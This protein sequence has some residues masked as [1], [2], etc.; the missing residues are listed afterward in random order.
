MGAS[1]EMSAQRRVL[2][3]LAPLARSWRRLRRRPLTMQMRTAAIIIA[4]VV[5]L[6]AWLMLAPSGTPGGA[7]SAGAAEVASAVTTGGTPA[8]QYEHT[9]GQ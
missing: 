1:M 4:I 6:V 7:G 3:P 8:Q 5:A 9:Q 2:N